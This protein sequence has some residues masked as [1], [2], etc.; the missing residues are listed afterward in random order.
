MR[1]TELSLLLFALSVPTSGLAEAPADAAG[2]D[3]IVP[4]HTPEERREAGLGIKA[5]PWLSLSTLLEVEATNDRTRP[6]GHTSERW[7]SDITTTGQAVPS[8]MLGAHLKAEIVLEWEDAGEGL[9]VD[10]GS[11]V[12]SEDGWDVSLGRL[13]L[14]FGIYY[15]HFVTGPV[16]EFA[17]SR[18]GALQLDVEL[19]NRF[20][21]AVYTF[22]HSAKDEVR[23]GGAWDWGASLEG[24]SEDERYVL[25][26]GYLSGL[27]SPNG[28][29]LG[30]P[31]DS[32]AESAGAW[33]AYALA[34]FG[35]WE[36]TFETVI[37]E[38]LL[39]DMDDGGHRAWSA[40]FETA[41]FVGDQWELAARIEH[42]RE[43][44]GAPKRQFGL[45][46]TWRANRYTSLSCDFL[47][48]SDATGFQ[49]DS[50]RLLERR[51]TI[52]A[53]IAVEF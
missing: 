5:T 53:R 40:N 35:S 52:A 46:A 3:N 23:G 17:E 15:S 8:V 29:G 21:A 20:E 41:L 48:G 51:D 44:R 12:F 30:N 47:A 6:V 9:V 34:R 49:D 28:T 10:E 2:A 42:S 43:V 38:P 25:G 7:S 18:A 45:A 14:P 27:A 33:N 11:L 19:G 26:L 50:G 32:A 22:H 16:I 4:Y 24:K 37:T 31:E 36:A 39:T 1:T 13:Y